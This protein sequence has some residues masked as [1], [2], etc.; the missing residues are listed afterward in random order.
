MAR[1]KV[2]KKIVLLGPAA[3]YIGLLI[4]LVAAFVTPSGWLYLALGVLGVIIGLLNITA[5]ESGPFLLA[6]IAFIV[7]V[8]GM[9]T[10]TIN[11]LSPVPEILTKEL[12]RLA[13]NLTV[14]IG[15]AAMVIA[16]RAI[17]EAAKG[18]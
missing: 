5:R 7:A 15:A 18:S 2:A 13:T 3:F 17:Y 9:G 12:L 16:L 10:L 8:W 14:L 1:A 11:T 6:A 4:A